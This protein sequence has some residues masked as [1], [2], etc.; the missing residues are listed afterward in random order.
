MFAQLTSGG[1][2][3]YLNISDAVTVGNFFGGRNLVVEKF[4]SNL[5]YT[6]VITPQCVTS[7]GA[8]PGP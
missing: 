8:H 6:R 4:K 1:N 2:Y 7:G 5:H 3:L